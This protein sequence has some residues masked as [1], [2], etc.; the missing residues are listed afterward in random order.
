MVTAARKVDVVDSQEGRS[1]LLDD[2]DEDGRLFE[3]CATTA[4]LL[5]RGKVDKV[6]LVVHWAHNLLE[7]RGDDDDDGV[8]VMYTNDQLRLV[9]GKV[10]CW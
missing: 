5:A 7:V 9:R 3:W 10:E 1:N 8:C 4:K 2:D 6:T